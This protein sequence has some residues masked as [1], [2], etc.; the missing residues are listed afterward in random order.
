MQIGNTIKE[1]MLTLGISQKQLAEHFSVSQ[2][3]ISKRLSANMTLQTL[4]DILTA[5]GCSYDIN[6]YL[7]NG[8]KF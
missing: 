2:A 8:K 4:E 1:L 3:N 7:P 6:I 5:L